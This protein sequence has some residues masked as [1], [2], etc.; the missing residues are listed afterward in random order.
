MDGSALY[1]ALEADQSS[2]H[3]GSGKWV[4]NRWRTVDGLLVPCQHGIHYC[5]R[6]QLVLWLGPTVWLFEDGSPEETLD[7]DD[8]MV[9][10]RGRIVEK[11]EAWKWPTWQLFA[12]DCAEAVLPL[13]EERFPNDD[14]PR[15]AIE[16]ARLHARGELP[17]AEAA[18]AAEAAWA[19]GAAGAA[20]TAWAAGAA[21][22]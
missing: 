8:K 20:G 2:A 1:K 7:R 18:E 10:R 21:G 9:T 5:R 19:A 22:A 17:A 14:R 6:D 13:F 11:V 4:K 12:A 3:G 15:K 16:A